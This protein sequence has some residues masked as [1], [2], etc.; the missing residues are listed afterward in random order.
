MLD[1]T[2]Q[3]PK[4]SV[5]AHVNL[6]PFIDLLSACISFLL[7][8][9]VWVQLGHLPAR[10]PAGGELE[11]PPRSVRLALDRDG[12]SLDEAVLPSKDGE[13]DLATLRER[14]GRAPARILD[15]RA[16]DGVRYRQLVAAMDVARAVGFEDISVGP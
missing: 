1:P 12:C 14:L 11:E 15:L 7:L 6:V 4:R 5:D 16:S 2:S 10:S 13:C 9:A 3:A 8:T